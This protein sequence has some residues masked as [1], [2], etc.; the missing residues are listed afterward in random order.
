ML[1]PFPRYNENMRVPP[2]IGIC[3]YLTRFGHDVSW[4][5]WSDDIHL[6]RPLFINSVQIFTTNERKIF[7]SMFML[8]RIFNKLPNIIVRMGNSYKI[9]KRGNYNLIFVRDDVFDGLVAYYIKTRYNI[10]FV[11]VLSNPLEQP[12]QYHKI[13]SKK[14]FISYYLICLIYMLAEMIATRLL[15]K[16]DLIIP[17]SK[18]LAEDLISNGISSKKIMPVPEGVDLEILRCQNGKNISEKYH[19]KGSKVIIY[20]G[21]LGKGRLLEFLIQAFSQVRNKRTH[22]KML[23]VGDGD[24]KEN[25][26]RICVDLGIDNCVIFTGQV[27]MHEV[28]S[29]IAISDIGV[30][31]IPPFSFYKISSPIKLFE[32]MAMGKPVIANEEILEHKKVLEL[33]GGGILVAYNT[34]SFSD[35]IIWLLDNPAKALELGKCGQSWVLKNRTYDL[36]AK[37]IEDR[38]L[39]LFEDV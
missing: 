29:Y 3:S 6:D 7:P 9:F 34:E 38:F 13:T 10:P 20:V 28:P 15:R 23:L 18:W 37:D 30:S 1:L 5:I 4:L 11:F 36:M 8:F 26:Q 25:L 2:Q 24:G 12:L 21:T 17:I 27:P 14:H 35:A 16:A 33:S 32:Y 19:L 39:N 22:A 31:P